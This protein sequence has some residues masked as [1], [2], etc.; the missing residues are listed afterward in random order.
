MQ[1]AVM[2]MGILISS[3]FA[4]CSSDDSNTN[5]NVSIVGE[6]KL[7]SKLMGGNTIQLGECEQGEGAIFLETEVVNFIIVDEIDSEPN[8]VQEGYEDCDFRY[9]PCDYLI[10][11]NNETLY[12]IVVGEGLI[13]GIDDSIIVFEIEVLTNQ[14]LRIKTVAKSNTGTIDDIEANSMEIE[15]S[16]QLTLIYTRV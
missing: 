6:W 7:S 10:T 15:E 5:E 8:I 9:A 1:K 4:G 11:E 3:L 13:E 16:E 14:D 2:L 12:R